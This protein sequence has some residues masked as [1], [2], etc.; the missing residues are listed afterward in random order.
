VLPAVVGT[1]LAFWLRPPGFEFRALAAC[2]FLAATVLAHAGFSLLEAFV[3]RESEGAWSRGRVLAAACACVAG[4]CLLGLHLSTVTTRFIFLVF[5]AATVFAGLL[6]TVP[7]PC[8]SQREGGEVVLA[9]SL[10]MFPVLGAYLVQT[11]DLTRPVYLTALPLVAAT[12][13]WRWTDEMANRSVDE[14]AGRGT[15]VRAFGPRFSGRVVVPAISLGLAASLGIAIASGSVPMQSLTAFVSLAFGWRIVTASW[16]DYS[17][18]LVMDHARRAAVA[19]HAVVCL[20]IA[21]SAL[22]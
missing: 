7:P 1:V 2:E 6:Y 9:T 11:G 3:T 4:A 14:Q 16:K 22:L 17:D 13:L 10:G 8:L 15:L 5:G 20:A 21:A 12:W 18:E 19:V